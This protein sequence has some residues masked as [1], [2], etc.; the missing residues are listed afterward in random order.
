[1]NGFARNRRP[2]LSEYTPLIFLSFRPFKARALGQGPAGLLRAVAPAERNGLV[3]DYNPLSS[4]GEQRHLNA[5]HI[6]MR[7]I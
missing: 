5:E 2:D 4:S 3:R 7:A 1:V 6:D